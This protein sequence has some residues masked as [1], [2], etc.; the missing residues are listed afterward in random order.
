M[1]SLFFYKVQSINMVE[2]RIDKLP[3]STIFRA[4]GKKLYCP[5]TLFLEKEARGL[6]EGGIITG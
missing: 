5:F 4:F 6:E 1:T 2:K 3:S